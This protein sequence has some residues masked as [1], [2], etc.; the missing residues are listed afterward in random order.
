MSEVVGWV[1]TAHTCTIRNCPG[2]HIHKEMALTSTEEALKLSIIYYGLLRDLSDLTGIEF[3]ME[4]RNQ[5]LQLVTDAVHEALGVVS[6]RCAKCDSSDIA[7]ICAE[8]GF[9]D[10]VDRMKGVVE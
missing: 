6:M 7:V 10:A 1:G 3:P 9:N 4:Y 2:P 8:C 5:A